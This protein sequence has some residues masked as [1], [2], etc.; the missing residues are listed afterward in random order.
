MKRTGRNRLDRL[1]CW[2][3]AVPLVERE[4]EGR[5]ELSEVKRIWCLERRLDLSILA[6]RPVFVW[7]FLRVLHRHC[8]SERMPKEQLFIKHLHICVQYPIE[9]FLSFLWPARATPHPSKE[10]W[11]PFN[12][13]LLS[14]CSLIS[15]AVFYLCLFLRSCSVIRLFDG[16][17][18]LV[19]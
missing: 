3:V 2:V 8:L 7:S 17:D 15:L 18:S 19:P 1:S 9:V 16:Q 13:L 10:L 12:T 14:L 6:Q 5:V 4:F 11:L